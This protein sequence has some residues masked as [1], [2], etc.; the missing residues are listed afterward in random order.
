MDYQLY[1]E[2]FSQQYKYG[3]IPPGAQFLN[4]CLVYLNPGEIYLHI[5]CQSEFYLIGAL[6]NHPTV[7]AYVVDCHPADSTFASARAEQLASALTDIGLEDQV[8]FCAQPLEEFF[9]DLQTITPVDKVG[10]YFHESVLDYRS[11]LLGL[12]LASPFLADHALIVVNQGQ[13]PQVRQAIADFVLTH[14]Q[15]KIL[16]GDVSSKQ[17]TGSGLAVLAW[18]VTLTNRQ[19]WQE[20][21]TYQVPEVIHRFR[22]FSESEVQDQTKAL[23]IEVKQAQQQGNWARVVESLQTLLQWDPDQAE[24]WQDLSVAQYSLGQNSEA[25]QAIHRAIAI[26]PKVGRYYHVLGVILEGLQQE[27]EAIQAHQTA[28]QLDPSIANSYNNLGLLHVANR[29]YAEAEAIYQQAIQACPDHYWAYINLYDLFKSCDRISEAVAIANQGIQRFP[30]NIAL[31]HAKYL[32]LPTLYTSEAEIQEYRA[33][34]SEGLTQLAQQIPLNTEAERQQSLFDISRCHNF[35]LTYQAQNDRQL[36]EQYG[37][38]V[39]RI[40]AAHSPAWVQP[41]QMPT[42]QPGERIRVG[43]VSQCFHTHSV[44]KLMLGWFRYANHDQFELFC[45][46]LGLIQDDYTKAFQ[47]SSAHYYQLLGSV[48]TICQQILANNLHILVFTDIG[49]HPATTVVAAA[50]LAPIQCAF[51]GHPITTGLPTMDYFI[52]SALMEPDNAQEFYCEK[53][54]SLP[55]LG[56]VYEWPQLPLQ[57]KPRPTF[58]ATYDT[59]KILN[60]DSILYLSCQSLFKYLPQ[61]DCVFPRIALKVPHARFLFVSWLPPAITDKFKQRL[62][63]AFQQVNLN[64]KDFCVVLPSLSKDDYLNLNQISDIYL[65]TFC[66]SGGNTTLEAVACGL[67]IVTC[68]GEFMRG[69][70]TYGI[71]K[72]LGVTEIIAKDIDNY[73]ELAVR[74]G[75][76]PEWRQQIVQ[77]ICQNRSKLYQDLSCIKALEAFYTEV[78]NR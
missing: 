17:V 42:L 53:L 66:W 9:C 72:M 36:Q 47:S 7:L 21:Q 39:H 28:I 23:G 59:D 16:L 15:C 44:G 60:D 10:V 58:I 37:Q 56:T 57:M 12:T 31:K 40:V 73:I 4:D 29:R 27:V 34:F 11:V 74:L 52:S 45:Y 18:D 35:L 8:F 2:Q 67:P 22:Q 78:M 38:L 20:L 75:L 41:R 76:D 6:Q 48:E 70:H 63:K 49:M 71:L 54:V 19:S 77:S 46:H 30:N 68:P 24:A 13:R 51:W 65:D 3:E 26:N 25:Y 14:P 61:H 43:Y 5:G 50:R 55:N 33:A 1:L 64:A 69:R 32:I 62:D